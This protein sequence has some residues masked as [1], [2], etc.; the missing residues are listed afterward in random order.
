MSTSSLVMARLIV[1][2]ED[3]NVCVMEVQKLSL[4]PEIHSW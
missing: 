4:V 1:A 3:L 2:L